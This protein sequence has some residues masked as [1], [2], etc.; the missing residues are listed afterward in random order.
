MQRFVSL[1]LFA[2]TFAGALEEKPM[3]LVVP[4]YNNIEWYETCLISMLAQ[5][6][7]NFR[8]IYLDDCSRD[9]MSQAIDAFLLENDPEH[10]VQMI[11]NRIRIGALANIY[12]A[13]QSCDPDEIVVL[14]DGDDWLLHPDVL[15]QLNE[16]YSTQ[17]V[18]FTH[19]NMKE[20]P[21][22]HVTWCEPIC[23]EAL[24]S[25]TYRAF[26][27]PSHLR[28]F[29]AWL[30][31]RIRYEDFL[32]EG[33]FFSMAWDMAIMYPIAEMAGRRHLFVEEPNYAYNMSNPINDNKVNAALQRKLDHYLR[34]CPPYPELSQ[35]KEWP[36]GR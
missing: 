22:G 7:H 24:L 13:V 12:Y 28:T 25:R 5:N 27:C 16:I 31:Q 14:V 18:W 17:E 26:K 4:S 36:Y 21:A 20:W 8:I 9:G 1:I 2:W 3:V 10:R 29:Y 23:E 33:Q 32:Y 19:G 11:H 15:S 35:A 30:F 34:T 6:Y